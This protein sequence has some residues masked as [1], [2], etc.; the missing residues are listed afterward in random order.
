MVFQSILNDVL[1]P[2]MRGPSSSHTA[3]SQRIGRTARSI[4]GG[5]PVFASFR[6]DPRGSY[7]R[8]YREQGADLAFVAGLM[9]WDLEDARFPEALELAAGEGLAVE[10]GETPLEGLDHPNAVRLRIRS[11]EGRTL[12]AAAKSTGGGGFLFD[13]VDG[14][15]TALD[16]KAH[17]LLVRAGRVASDEEAASWARGRG[18]TCFRR[19]E[20]GDVVQ[21]TFESPD[22]F[23][24]AEVELWRAK[25]GT[26]S[27]RT[28][29]PSFLVRRGEPIA[30][31]GREL[32]ALAER[33]KWSLGRTALAYEARLLGI[34]EEEATA[35]IMA[36]YG[37]MR[38]AVE[39]GLRDDGLRLRLLDPSARGVLDAER[40]GRLAVGGPHARAAAWAMAALHVSNSGGVVCA[41]P[42]GASSGV[43]PGVLTTLAEEMGLDDARTAGCLWAAG[44]VGLVVALRATFAAEVAG[45][46][47]EI[48]A[49]GAMAAAAVVEA[50]GG[51]AARALDA[52][53]ISF[54]NAMGSV[55]DLVQGYC[56]IPCHTRNAAAAS[57]ALTAA[58]LVLGGYVNPVPLDETVDAVLATGLMLPCELRC[59]SRGGIALA[60]SALRLPVRPGGG[61][62]RR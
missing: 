52:A 39:F 54:Q 5:R 20:S 4:L 1:G 6:F 16:G 42:T 21:W 3:G 23:A 28:A 14:V 27:V 22:P 30:G 11:I 26:R 48:G 53:A 47:V 55:C 32:A 29:E 40:S 50:A 25:A 33:N 61:K 17:V 2:V 36:R 46:Q 34:S 18:R 9:G 38:T 7:A 24:P 13:E 51:S 57:A 12:E 8:T 56:E 49:A 43:L 19:S 58:D 59:T 37:V 35:E 60:P 10:F 15:P 62:G 41:A 44:A 45:C 31:S